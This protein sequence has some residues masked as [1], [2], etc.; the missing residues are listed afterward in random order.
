MHARRLSRLIKLQTS[1]KTG[2]LSVYDNRPWFPGKSIALQ[3]TFFISLSAVQFRI[4]TWWAKMPKVKPNAKPRATRFLNA[5]NLQHMPS[6]W[7]AFG[8]TKNLCRFW[9]GFFL[10]LP[11]WSFFLLL[12]ANTDYL[13]Y[14][15]LWKFLLH[16]TVVL[17]Q[18]KW[19]HFSDFGLKSNF[20]R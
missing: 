18:R 16:A 2:P 4:T 8:Q 9:Q 19:K 12:Q 17:D 11:K 20:L 13:N 3:H 15:S 14:V 6:F 7:K 1:G 5:P 10:C